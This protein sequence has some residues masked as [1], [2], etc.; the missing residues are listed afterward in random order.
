MDTQALVDSM[1]KTTKQI[2]QLKEQQEKLS[3]K[4]KEG[5]EQF[6]ANEAALKSLTTAQRLQTT[7]LAAQTTEDGRLISVKK[8]VKDAVNDVNNSENDYVANNK[9]LIELKKQL[10]SNDEDYEK[11]LAKINGKLLENNNWLEE[12]GSAH[13]KLVTTMN[14]YKQQVADS[15]NEINIFNGGLSGFIS[16]AQEAGGVGPLVKGAFEG[17][18]SGIMGMTKSA[19]AFM[20]TPLGAALTVISALLSPIIDY[21]T[22]T[23]EGI[24]KVTA[25]TRPLQEVFSALSGVFQDIGK[26][27]TDAFTSPKKSMEDLYAFVK[28]NLIN[29]FTAFGTILEGIMTMD[30]K[31]ISNG[32]LQAATGVEDVIGKTQKAAQA[33]GTFFDEAYKRGQQIDTLQKQLDKS[34]A[35]YT[36]Q[37]GS[38]TNQLD[39]QKKIADDTNLSY[40][41]REKAAQ[42]AIEIAK[43]QNKLALD[44]MDTEI[45]LTK[46]KMGDGEL[47]SKQKQEIA[48]LQIKRNEAA[49]N[50]KESEKGLHDKLD[51]IR[52]DATDKEMK[53]RQKLMDDALEKQRQTLALYEAEN[54]GSNKTLDEA[55]AYEKE[56]AKQSLDILKNQLRLKKIS[57]L[58]YSAAI[59]DIEAIQLQNTLQL[60]IDNGKALLDMELAKGKSLLANG[61][62]ITEEL[63]ILEKNRLEKEK[64]LKLNQLALERGISKDKMN[65]SEEEARVAGTA[66]I[67]YYNERLK[68]ELEYAGRLADAENFKKNQEDALNAVEKQEA[69]DKAALDYENNTTEYQ[70]KIDLEDTRKQEEAAKYQQWLDDKI[71]TEAEHTEYS[72]ALD[73]ESAKNKQRLALQNAQ[74]QLGSMQSVANALTEAFGQSKELA[75]A[76]ATMN[77]G[78]AIL[79][80]WSGTITGN[81]IVDTVLKGALTASTAVK[82]AKQIKEIQSAKK[83]KSPKLE[84]GGLMSIGGSRHSGG[85]T[86]FTGADGTRFEA[87]QGEL[88][89]VMN[90]NAARH[91]MAFNNAFPAGSAAAPNYF[92]GGGIVSREIA[93]QSL[94][95]DELALKI[96]QANKS[97]PPPVVAVQDIV[98]QGNDYVRIRDAANF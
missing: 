54:K 13:A 11:R 92:A 57:V 31:K 78:Q 29:R 8:A 98:T 18:G 19:M 14:D 97:L 38:L 55:I 27:L 90:R 70:K 10:N 36:T 87:E 79:S 95:T 65:M 49:A 12:N 56:I 50:Y 26:F 3:R 41:E 4:G 75:I 94:N 53:R 58:E 74:T 62:E 71:I 42:K 9:R 22:N 63:L 17:V 76:Q 39:T 25:I 2:E 51:D 21:L 40:G 32:V 52:Q 93:Q 96:A 73:E 83:P 86:L 46:L 7:A 61:E 43:Q 33:T 30:F 45:K 6:Q 67:N 66:A 91:F 15:F 77:A 72:K 89:G 48:E 88:I 20:A 44:R 5:T 23:E 59:K 64:Q 37:M 28:Q 34:Q 60:Q 1:Q 80:I 69:L 84:K 82:T 24:D 16:R 85:G 68:I 47:D 35:D 81:P